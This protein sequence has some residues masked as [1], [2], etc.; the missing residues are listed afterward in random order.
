[1]SAFNG[2]KMTAAGI[3]LEEKLKA[4][5]REMVFSGV[6]LGDGTLGGQDIKDLTAL[7]SPQLTLPIA[8]TQI[9]KNGGWDICALL[10]S[11]K[12]TTPFYFREWGITAQDP[13]TGA[14]VLLL[15]ANSGTKADYLEPWADGSSGT[16]IETELVCTCHVSDEIN[17]TAVVEQGQ[18]VD[19]EEFEEFKEA[20]ENILSDKADLIGGKVPSTQLDITPTTIINNL[21]S[22]STTAALSANMGSILK[23][24]TVGR[25]PSGNI[26]TGYAADFAENKG[27]VGL[28]ALGASALG[29]AKN[30][31][32]NIGVGQMALRY[33]ETGDHNVS[34]GGGPNIVNGNR[35]VFIGNLSGR[36]AENVNDTI[37]IGYIADVRDGDNQIVIGSNTMGAGANTITLGNN[38]MT[39]LRC[40]VTTITQFSDSR[41]KEDIKPADNK[42]CLEAVNKLPVSRYKYKDFMGKRL[43]KHVTGWMADDYE[44]VFPKG[45]QMNDEVFPVLDENG[46]EIWEDEVFYTTE[47]KEDGEEYKKENVQKVRKTFTMENV[48]NITPSEALPTL[49]GAVQCLSQKI[50]EMQKEVDALKGEKK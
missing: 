18:F 10:D 7:I 34:L 37:T 38:A 27:N 2:H 46:E 5:G 6:Q 12:V 32:S 4:T 8:K 30:T 23:R 40:A 16:Y 33:L 41:V 26:G 48:K 43:D 3:V 20:N 44:K 39:Q 45:V 15:Y 35:N 21:I 31:S 42:M 11:T 49:W 29:L 1:M 50:D 22:T 13:D 25:D 14:D 36:N 47:L 24:F 9:N 17:V 19:K 28:V